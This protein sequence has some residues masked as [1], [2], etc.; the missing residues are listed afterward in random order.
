MT[1]EETARMLEELGASHF[2]EKPCRVCGK[3]VK[4]AVIGPS[5][6]D[7][8]DPLCSLHAEAP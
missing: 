6:A 4:L 3:T 5:D 2:V 7:E 1:A 8:W